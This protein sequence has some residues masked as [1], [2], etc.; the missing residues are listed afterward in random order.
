MFVVGTFLSRDTDHLTGLKQKTKG[1]GVNGGVTNMS[2]HGALYFSSATC[3][4]L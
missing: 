1:N 2:C 4:Y 3:I